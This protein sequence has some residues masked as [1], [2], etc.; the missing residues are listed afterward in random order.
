MNISVIGPVKNE[1]DFIGYSIMD[2]LEHVHEFVY[3]VAK[4]EDGTDELLDYIK[5]R[6][7]G[8]KLKILRAPEFDFNPHDQPSY[9]NA[10]NTCIRESSGDAVWFKHPDMICTNAAELKNI[11]PGPL[12]WFTRMTSYA[13]DFNTQ[14]TKG[15]TGRWKNIHAKKFGLHYYGGYGSINED[16]YH[17]DITGNAHEFYG[18]NFNAYPFKVADSGLN[19]NHYC[20]L[21]G[22]K[23]RFEKMTACLRTLFPKFTEGRI[24]EMAMNHPRV[25]L[26]PDLTNVWGFEFKHVDTPIPAVFEKYRD[27]F[28]NVL[29]RKAA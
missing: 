28:N 23:R 21:K 8:D 29:G 18:D 3:A 16:F 11:K 24:E 26:Q 27:E 1:A 14:I 6:Y 13:G 2:C 25:T 12:A 9:N 19:I 17:K 20:E 15:R 22:Y 5:E 4:S 7:A 10:F